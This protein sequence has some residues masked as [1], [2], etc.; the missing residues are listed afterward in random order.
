MSAVDKAY[1]VFTVA[2]AALLLALL[3]LD[4]T[5]SKSQSFASFVFDPSGYP[6]GRDFINTWV[7]GRSVFSGGP[8]PWFDFTAYNAVRPFPSISGPIRLTS[9]SS[10]GRSAFC[11]S[12]LPMGSGASAGWRS[13]CSLRGL[14]GS[15]G[16][17]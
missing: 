14:A 2:A 5:I 13:I 16:A 12:S 9:C 15:A 10:R 3:E 11:L 8:A 4:F 17:P 7:G 1:V 6:I